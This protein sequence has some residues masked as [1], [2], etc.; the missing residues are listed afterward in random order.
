MKDV[1]QHNEKINAD[2][3]I[4][5]EE[6]VDQTG[7]KVEF[8]YKLFQKKRDGVP[9]RYSKLTI[10]LYNTTSRLLA[11]GPRVD[12]TTDIILKDLLNILRVKCRDIEV[13]DQ[14]IKESI[15]VA[16]RDPDQLQIQNYNGILHDSINEQLA[17]CSHCILSICNIYLFPVLVLRAGFAF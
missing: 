14:N 6:G 8:R 11:N 1:L 17:I 9:G 10:S 13:V 16:R 7:S 2:F 15:T 3:C 5:F 12:M 4:K